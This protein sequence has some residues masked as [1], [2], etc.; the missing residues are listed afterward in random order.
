MDKQKFKEIHFVLAA[1]DIMVV[2]Y[3]ILYYVIGLH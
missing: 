3:I 1:I 2:S